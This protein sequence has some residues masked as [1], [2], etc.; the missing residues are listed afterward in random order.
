MSVDSLS[1]YP[2]VSS[3]KYSTSF[4]GTCTRSRF[5]VLTANYLGLEKNNYGTKENHNSKAA[6]AFGPT[7]IISDSCHCVV[8]FFMHCSAA[9]C[10]SIAL[11]RH[12]R[13][14]QIP[15]IRREKNQCR[16]LLYRG[17]LLDSLSF[18]RVCCRGFP[19]RELNR[20]EVR[21]RRRAKARG[22]EAA[23]GPRQPGCKDRV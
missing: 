22:N 15:A 12:A 8:H 18:K 13:A 9:L 3:V 23:P 10:L 1:A 19:A 5:P 4:A 11:L 14:N 20:D 16:G 2:S 21:R 17:P 7:H 6:G